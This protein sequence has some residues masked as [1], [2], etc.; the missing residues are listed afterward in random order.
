MRLLKL[1]ICDYP[2]YGTDIVKCAEAYLTIWQFDEYFFQMS[3]E[4]TRVK[5]LILLFYILR[6]VVSN[7][8]LSQQICEFIISEV[9][10]FEVSVLSK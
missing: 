3:A 9:N 5:V 7:S 1:K 4:G 2:L 10:K 6:V 8:C